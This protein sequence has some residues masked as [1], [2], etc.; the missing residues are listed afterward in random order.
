MGRVAVGGV[1][2]VPCEPMSLRLRR[3]GMGRR[4]FLARL[5]GS[6]AGAAIAS[7][8]DL[9][10]LLWVPTP[11]IT[12]PAM[13]AWRANDGRIY[14]YARAD[15]DLHIGD[16]VFAADRIVGVAVGDVRAG[17]YGWLQVYGPAVVR[18]A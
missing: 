11:I 15:R 4:D 1:S 6:A 16:F 3:G 17:H 7:T 9:D 13:P 14:R 18:V 5:L 2:C 12:V 8:V 10:R